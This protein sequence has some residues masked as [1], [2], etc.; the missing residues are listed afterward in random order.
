MDVDGTKGVGASSINMSAH[1]KGEAAES[2]RGRWKRLYRD[3]QLER[4]AVQGVCAKHVKF[5]VPSPP[6]SGSEMSSRKGAF[7]AILESTAGSKRSLSDD[8][9]LVFSMDSTSSESLEYKSANDR[10]VSCK[11]VCTERVEA[12]VGVD[13]AMVHV[14]KEIDGGEEELQE[15]RR[16]SVGE[17]KEEG[18]TPKEATGPGA[19]GQLTGAL[20]DAR[21]EP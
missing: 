5:G 8:Q 7:A 12:V 2:I 13:G 6:N 19:A 1:T 4:A 11:R 21:Q 15:R 16:E 14:T 9:N 20:D 18:G 10:T 3:E 17:E